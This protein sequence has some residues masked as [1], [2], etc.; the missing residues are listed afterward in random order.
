MDMGGKSDPFCIIYAGNEQRR[1]ATIR[2]NLNP[3][4]NENYELCVSEPPVRPVSFDLMRPFCSFL[5]GLDHNI[6]VLVMDEDPKGRADLLGSI[7]VPLST[8]SDQS[9]HDKWFDVLDSK[10]GKAGRLH[11]LVNFLY[12]VVRSHTSMCTQYL[13]LI[14]L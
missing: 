10:G 13:F 11:L 3:A 9:Y 4:W 5:E 12:D 6:H 2:N 8:F 14:L 7:S 1:S